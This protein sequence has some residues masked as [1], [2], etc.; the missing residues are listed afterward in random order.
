MKILFS[1]LMKILCFM[2]IL[3]QE[4]IKRLIFNEATPENE[5][6]IFCNEDSKEYTFGVSNLH[7]YEGH[8]LYFEPNNEKQ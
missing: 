6:S 8:Y 3:K 1:E 4:D 5:I 7:Y 2:H